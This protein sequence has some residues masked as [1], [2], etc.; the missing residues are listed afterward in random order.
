MLGG[1]G[2]A[3]LEG[4]R[5]REDVEPRPGVGGRPQP[6][7]EE[8]RRLPACQP[9]P[10]TP[11]GRCTRACCARRRESPRQPAFA[12][13]FRTKLS[14]GAFA[15]EARGGDSAARRAARA[16][17][18]LPA[19]S[20]SASSAAGERGRSSPAR[21]RRLSPGASARL[22]ADA[23][24]ISAPHGARTYRAP[25]PRAARR[26]APARRR[27]RR[28]GRR[29]GCIWGRAGADRE[30]NAAEQR[31]GVRGV[32][33]ADVRREVDA[34]GARRGGLQAQRLDRESRKPARAAQRGVGGDGHARER[35]VADRELEVRGDLRRHAEP[36][37]VS[38]D[39]RRCRDVSG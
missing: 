24:P 7:G 17:T 16:R 36:E 29:P 10:V 21:V 35:D 8:R 33:K 38:S 30:E 20:P 18:D 25:R 4:E 34:G 22:S 11:V 27:A 1:A 2:R 3:D 28:A 14:H 31:G 15:R 9:A 19:A 32:P 6:Y 12:R 26:R 23:A 37:A 5:G 39:K 13:S